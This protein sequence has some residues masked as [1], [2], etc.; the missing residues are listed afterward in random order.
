MFGETNESETFENGW[1]FLHKNTGNLAKRSGLALNGFLE[2]R[3]REIRKIFQI[4]IGFGL[5]S[6]ISLF[7]SHALNWVSAQNEFLLFLLI[8]TFLH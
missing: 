8:E 6:V 7:E 5:V 3:F 1:V 2:F 4:N